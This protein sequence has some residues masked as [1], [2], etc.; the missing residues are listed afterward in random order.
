[1]TIV[2]NEFA[3]TVAFEMQKAPGFSQI[4]A[5]AIRDASCAGYDNAGLLDASLESAF[6]PD[7]A[8]SLKD[9]IAVFDSVGPSTRYFG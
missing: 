1:M 3:L 4:L 8:L 2:S 9:V 7:A 5:D 6:L